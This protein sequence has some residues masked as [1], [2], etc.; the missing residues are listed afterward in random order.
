MVGLLVVGLLA[1][2]GPATAQLAD[3]LTLASSGVLLPY[4]ATL[5]NVSIIELASPV[6]DNGTLHMIFYN[7]DC[8]RVISV[9]EPV[10]TNDLTLVVVSGSPGVIPGTP[11]T[12]SG[13]NG[14]VAV[15]E[16]LN[17]NDLI[18][19]VNPLHTRVYWINL[20]NG[21]ARVL[22]PIT[23]D[24]YGASGL[25][26]WNPL[27]SGAT[28]FAPQ[29]NPPAIETT[30]YLIC[31]K[32]TIQG[33]S[34]PPLPAFPVPVVLVNGNPV[35]GGFPDISPDFLSAYP[36]GSIAGRVYDTDE[37]LLVNII[38][39]CDCLQINPLATFGGA[40]S[41]YAGTP[42][43]T[44]TELFS[45]VPSPNGFGFTG[46][47]AISIGA[48]ATDFFGRLSNAQGTQLPDNNNPA[49]QGSGR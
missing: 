36:N 44:Y 14:L 24:T 48:G 3:P 23:L 7:Q 6:N 12:P 28:F 30:L 47:K 39:P 5:N 43:G 18:P 22:E 17:G 2:A 15:A 40:G 38:S 37:N 42:G 20:V 31:P 9:P 10:T 16:S 4:F 29:N 21:R 45:T 34:G 8:A 1:V 26:V 19:L 46:Y 13:I 32:T 11:G 35:S 25:V 49:L 41:T 33:A 27:R